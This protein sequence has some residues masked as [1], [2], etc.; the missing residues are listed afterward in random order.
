MCIRDSQLALL[1][2]RDAAKHRIAL[3]SF[4]NVLVI[5]QRPGIYKLIRIGDLRP[6]GYLCDRHRVVPGNDLHGHSLLPEVAEGGREMC[7][8]DRVR[9]SGVCSA[10]SFL[11]LGVSPPTVSFSSTI[12]V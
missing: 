4:S 8:R 7:I 5:G 3:R 6:S 9:S 10:V 11:I 1:L 12:G 2:R